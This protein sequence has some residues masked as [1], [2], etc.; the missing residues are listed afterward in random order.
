MPFNAF[1]EGIRQ[2]VGL[3]AKEMITSFGIDVLRRLG[4]WPVSYPNN[5]DETSVNRVIEYDIAS[6][7]V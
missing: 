6:S 5:V 1:S 3:D 7:V 2:T 4:D